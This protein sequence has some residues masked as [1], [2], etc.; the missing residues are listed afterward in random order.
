M[1][2]PL[3]WMINLKTILMIIQTGWVC[4]FQTHHPWLSS[5][6]FLSHSTHHRW[7]LLC[8][9]L[10][11]V[12]CVFRIRYWHAGSYAG[13]GAAESICPKVYASPSLKSLWLQDIP[14]AS[15]G[16]RLCKSLKHKNC[17]R[18]LCRYNAEITF[19]NIL[20]ISSAPRSILAFELTHPLID[21]FLVVST[22]Y[23]PRNF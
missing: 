9:M 15:S 19:T 10:R 3:F 23:W 13:I 16:N 22:D 1:A 21:V 7:S 8:N 17:S 11:D 14:L 5:L 6:L 20:L 4:T 2:V 12:D 18:L